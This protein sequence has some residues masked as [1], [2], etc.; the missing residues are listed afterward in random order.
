MEGKPLEVSFFEAQEG[1]DRFESE[2]FGF[3]GSA[4]AVIWD[5]E[6]KKSTQFREGV[7]VAIIAR[8]GTMAGVSTNGQEFDFRPVQ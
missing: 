2:D 6:K 3:E 1:L 4:S 7:G 8:G 5:D